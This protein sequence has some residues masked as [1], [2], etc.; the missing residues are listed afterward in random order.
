MGIFAHCIG[1]D[2]ARGSFGQ[3]GTRGA[4]AEIHSDGIDFLSRSDSD[5]LTF[6]AFCPCYG[7]QRFLPAILYFFGELSLCFPYKNIIYHFSVFV[8]FII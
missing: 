5:F 8:N 7:G 2:L 3:H 1:N 4:G 6:S